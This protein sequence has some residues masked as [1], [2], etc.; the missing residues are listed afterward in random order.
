MHVGLLCT[1]C[2]DTG[3]R[4]EARS[5]ASVF[6]TIGDMNNPNVSI[7][8]LTLGG[9]GNNVWMLI[10]SGEVLVVDAPFEAEAII[11]AA[12]EYTPV[13]IAITHGHFDHI[14]AALE[15]RD[16]TENTPIY[17]HPDDSFLWQQ[18]HGS[19]EYDQSLTDGQEI[20]VGETSVR[21]LHTPGHTPGSVCYYVNSLNTVITGDT[22]FPGGPGATRWEYSDFDQIIASIR[23][24]LFTLPDDT[25]VLPGHGP[26]TTIGTE[27]P[28]LQEWI[29]RGW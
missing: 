8:Q 1:I 6:D 26:S 7:A 18:Q 17:L 16:R 28:K 27:K 4:P 12:L 22:L 29:E 11:D 9:L 5:V 19:S 14:N 23:N 20:R 15:L 24:K 10:N 25:R 21:V 13:G 2:L 3:Y